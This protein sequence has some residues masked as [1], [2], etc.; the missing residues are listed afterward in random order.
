MH[1]PTKVKHGNTL[2]SCINSHNVNKHPLVISLIQHFKKL[3]T[4]LVILLFQMIL[5][6]CAKHFLA[7]L[8][9]KSCDVPYG[10]NACVT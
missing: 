5:K 10:E 6:H 9:A 7:F 2:P 1:F 3:C 4:F 8:S